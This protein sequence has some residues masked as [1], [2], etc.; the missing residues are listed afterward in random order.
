MTGVLAHLNGLWWPAMD[1]D[2]RAVILR[3]CAPSIAELLTHVRGRDLIVQ[4]GAN[5]GTY[6]LALAD[7]FQSV[8]TCEP[9]PT[10]YACLKMNLE[11]RDSLKRVTAIAAAFGETEGE[12]APL[13][14]QPRNCGAHR[15][16]FGKGPVPVWTIDALLD[17]LG[18]EA[19]DCIWLDLEGSELFALRGAKRT[20]ER[21]SPVM[22]VE[23]KG[24]DHQFFGVEP[25]SLQKFLASFGYSEVA[26][27]GRDKVFK[28][29]A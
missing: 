7:V 24:L 12:C 21:F 14:V 16:S 26:R 18:A 22:C 19:C 20:I 29:I 5:V 6:P 1:T 4:A 17:D 28:R 10:N 11:A 9:D 23:D 15:V 13:E 2:A 27:I 25:G 3:D 8:I